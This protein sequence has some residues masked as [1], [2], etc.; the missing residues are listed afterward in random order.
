MEPFINKVHNEFQTMP[1]FWSL[2]IRIQ[3]TLAHMHD[4]AFNLI[5]T[6]LIRGF[7]IKNSIFH[8]FRFS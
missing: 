8:N 2:I 4:Y 3:V 1:Y 7:E 6:R 5:L